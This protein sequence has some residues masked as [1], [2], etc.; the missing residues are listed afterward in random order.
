MGLLQKLQ[1]QAEA[2][3]ERDRA[4]RERADAAEDRRGAA[5]AF[6]RANP[7]LLKAVGSGFSGNTGLVQG[8][9]S[10]DPS[11]RQLAGAAAG[12]II[13]E[14]DR[15][16][17]LQQQD[18]QSRQQDALLE[19][20]RNKQRFGGLTPELYGKNLRTIIGMAQGR[21]NIE[22]L[23]TLN[24]EFGRE[25]LPGRARGA[26]S[27]LRGQ[28][29]NTLRLQFEAGALQA[30]ELEFFESMI[31]TFDTFASL[32]SA[33]RDIQLKTLQDQIG[34]TLQGWVMSTPNTQMPEV[35]GRPIG[36]ILG[37]PPPPAGTEVVEPG[38]FDK[39]VEQEKKLLGPLAGA[40]E[41][42]AEFI[43]RG[44]GGR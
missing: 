41:N 42:T 32:S 44:G 15:Q 3:F 29:L 12:S 17:G 19:E 26:Y 22:D 27:A 7:D 20:A 1:A 40:A 37:E 31:P 4:A 35:F 5:D 39:L 6:I 8:L 38:L 9:S 10:E 13:G 33:Q 43:R 36:E 16:F 24:N 28:V 30:A 25:A 23:R 34:M 21:N 11:A 18:F 2:E 14:R